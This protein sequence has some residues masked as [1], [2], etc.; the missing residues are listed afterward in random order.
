[1]LSLSSQCQEQMWSQHRW[2]NDWSEA[3]T[4]VFP[5]TAG[6]PSTLPVSQEFNVTLHACPTYVL[7]SSKAQLSGSPVPS[8]P[9]NP[10]AL[11]H[12]SAISAAPDGSSCD[13]QPELCSRCDKLTSRTHLNSQLGWVRV[14]KICI[15]H[16]TFQLL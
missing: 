11:A 15:M 4:E 5:E 12:S 7:I 14:P 10:L 2:Q 3:V 9:A 13:I 16:L 8:V 6:S 1:M